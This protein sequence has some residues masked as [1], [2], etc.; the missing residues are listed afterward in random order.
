MASQRP[1]SSQRR[2]NQIKNL[3]PQVERQLLVVMQAYDEEIQRLE[4]AKKV[5]MEKTKS[6]VD[7]TQQLLYTQDIGVA[8]TKSQGEI[9]ADHAAAKECQGNM[10]QLLGRLVATPGDLEQLCCACQQATPLETVD[11]SLSAADPDPVQLAP[12]D[13]PQAGTIDYSLP[14]PIQHLRPAIL[15][16]PRE[17]EPKSE[18]CPVCFDL[19]PDRHSRAWARCCHSFHQICYD[20]LRQHNGFCP[21]CRTAL[22]DPPNNRTTGS[23]TNYDENW[24]N[25]VRLPPESPL[26]TPREAWAMLS[27]E[28]KDE[29]E[30]MISSRISKLIHSE[31]TNQQQGPVG[32]IN[33]QWGPGGRRNQPQ[34][35]PRGS[36]GRRGGWFR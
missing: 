10:L 30:A 19:L 22:L 15:L 27:E 28:Q 1:K 35:S 31:R 17:E 2:L 23:P 34:W 9:A 21:L 8:G 3:I 24:N 6:T 18:M 16:R 25:G 12:L 20:G 14:P 36:E 4:K 29:D 13:P 33:Q 11:S 26:M 5:L 7:R 32:R